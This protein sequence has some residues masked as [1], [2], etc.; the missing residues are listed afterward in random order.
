[1]GG[2]LGLFKPE[3][4][5]FQKKKLMH[6]FY[7]FFD[8]NKDGKLEWK[9]F[10]LARQKV[11]EM[12]GWK[13]GT[14]K[15]IH[16]QETFIQIWRKLQDDGDSNCDGVISTDEW[17]KMWEHFNAECAKSAQNT[18]ENGSGM[19]I[20]GWLEK[21]IE[22]KFNLYDRTGDGVVDLEEYEYVLS[23]FGVPPKDARAAFLMFSGNHEKKIDLEYFTILSAEYFRSDD[24]GALGNFI[25]GKLTFDD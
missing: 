6:E 16:T 13:V 1:M 20:P 25:T 18:N 15:Y 11:C 3:L 12:S 22:Y 19:K 17:L 7:T 14:K 10:D 21:Y 8:L 4:S 5:D 2:V 23:D 9:D 24:A